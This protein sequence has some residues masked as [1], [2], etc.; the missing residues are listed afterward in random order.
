[1]RQVEFLY[2]SQRDVIDVGLTLT[3]AVGIVED[4]LREH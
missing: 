4:A 1:M 2:L 3:D